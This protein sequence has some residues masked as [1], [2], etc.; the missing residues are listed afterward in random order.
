MWV[1]MMNGIPRNQSGA[2]IPTMWPQPEVMWIGM[3]M[4]QGTRDKGQW[5]HRVKPEVAHKTGSD[6]YNSPNRFIPDPSVPE[7]PRLH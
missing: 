3:Q 1:V 5:R 7:T 6:A 4:S 2:S